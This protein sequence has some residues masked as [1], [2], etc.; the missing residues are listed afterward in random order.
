MSVFVD[1][2]LDPD[3]PEARRWLL[4]ELSR[5]R[6]QEA[7]P[8]WFDQASKAFWDWVASLFSGAGGGDGAQVA[9]IV[10]IVIAAV[11][12]ATVVIVGIPRRSRRRRGPDAVFGAGDE[13]SAAD[14]RAASVAAARAGDWTTAIE[15][16]FRAIAMECVERTIIG[17][18]PGTTAGELARLLGSVFPDH[19][20]RLRRGA[21][22]FDGVRYLDEPGRAADYEELVALDEEIRALRPALHET[23]AAPS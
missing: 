2:P 15:E 13:R 12:T 21:R 17:M 23:V 16:R 1:I 18:L 9:T 3:A 5:P 11:V 14:L 19:A 4:D 22:L 6:Y 20:G 8:T 7:K 10:V